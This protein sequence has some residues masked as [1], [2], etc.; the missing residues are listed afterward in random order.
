MAAIATKQIH[1]K[2]ADRTVLK[3]QAPAGEEEI[4]ACPSRPVHSASS[5]AGSAL[6]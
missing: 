5:I 2:P 4:L 6:I 1:A 3:M